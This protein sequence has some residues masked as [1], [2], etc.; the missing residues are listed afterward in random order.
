[1]TGE[2]GALGLLGIEVVLMVPRHP[3]SPSLNP[4]QVEA[5]RPTT[6]A[7]IVD[8]IHK[9]KRIASELNALARRNPGSPVWGGRDMGQAIRT[10]TEG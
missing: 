5:L 8:S 3:L 9:Q 7:A 4:C 6:A 2:L 1:M 10:A